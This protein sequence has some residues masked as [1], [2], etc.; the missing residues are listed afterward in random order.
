MDEGRL[1]RLREA[2]TRA[3]EKRMLGEGDY[4]GQVKATRERRR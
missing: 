3:K 2:R 4:C 1:V